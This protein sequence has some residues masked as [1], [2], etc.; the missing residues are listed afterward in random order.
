MFKP[1]NT[2]RGKLVLV[3]DKPPKE[4]LCNLVYGLTCVAPDCGE[5]YV[6]E[7]KQSLDSTNTTTL[8]QTKHRTLQFT[9]TARLPTTFLNLRLSS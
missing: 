2:L 5:L 9:I 3:K 1:I 8:A 7:I 4:K 6:G